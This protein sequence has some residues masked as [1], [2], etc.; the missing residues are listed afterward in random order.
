MEHI[1]AVETRSERETPL[2]RFL[3]GLGEFAEALLRTVVLSAILTPVLLASILTVD[4]PFRALD[5]FFIEPA[6]RPSL[7]LSWGLVIMAA[8]PLLIILYAR[9]YGGE[10][11]SRVV[12]ASWAVSAMAVFAEVSYLAPDLEAGDF[13]ST[14]FVLAFT[15]SSMAA[16]YF[17]AALYDVLRGGGAWW[18]APLYAAMTA[19]AVGA[20]LYFPIGFWGVDAPWLHWLVGHLAVK[21]AAAFAFLPVYHAL[22]RPLRPRGGYGGDWR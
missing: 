3:R 11:A 15:I 1:V 16:Q 22:K 4:L 6:L 20:A 14:R 17:A 13:P 7:W 21:L 2:Q 18:R 12:T 10:E 5:R 9:R 8:G 19:Y